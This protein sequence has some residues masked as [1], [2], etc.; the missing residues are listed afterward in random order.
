MARKKWSFWLQSLIYLLF[1]SVISYTFFV[2]D[3][4]FFDLYGAYSVFPNETIIKGILLVVLTFAIFLIKRSLIFFIFVYLALTISY[5]VEFKELF[6]R[7]LFPVIIY[8]GI[9][10]IALTLTWR[11]IFLLRDKYTVFLILLTLPLVILLYYSSWNHIIYNVEGEFD[12]GRYELLSAN[13]AASIFLL[14]VISIQKF[15]EKMRVTI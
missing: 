2:Y 8:I 7:L 14:V 4:P 3:T 13:L 15:M 6:V 10:S 5:Y 1:L 9:L 11:N 12:Y